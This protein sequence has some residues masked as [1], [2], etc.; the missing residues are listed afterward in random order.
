MG[1]RQ[2]SGDGHA[3]NWLVPIVAIA[4]M[5]LLGAGVCAVFFSRNGPGTV[6][7]L[8]I[9]LLALFVALYH[10]RIRSMEFGGAKIQL[11]LQ[12]KDWLKEAFELRLAGNYE[13]AEDTLQFAF[14]QF[15]QESET[16]WKEYQTATEY[17][18]RV[19]K[20]LQK[21][22]KGNDNGFNG[23]IRKT[24]SGLSLLPLIDLVMDFD[25]P[26]VLE[27]LTARGL[28]LCPELIEHLQQ[29]KLRA[30]VIVRPGQSLNSEELVAKLGEEVKNGA[31]RLTCFLLIQNCKGSES[32]KEFRSLA[33]RRGMHATSLEWE[34]YSGREKL[35]DAL[36]E[37]ILTV[38]DPS[39]CISQAM[40]QALPGLPRPPGH[41]QMETDLRLDRRRD[42]HLFGRCA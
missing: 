6:A 4:A 19:R 25:G 21:I 38:C 1:K 32:A 13:Q 37:A 18:E 5:G 8:T 9:G 30:G 28:T 11:A 15:A 14:R 20:N 34:P 27:A 31:L 41:P 40:Q 22:V 35:A 17:Q 36:Q 16:R 12:I 3:L 7:L 23:R 2:T 10:D 39:Q 26:S 42:G 24:A 29:H 33:I